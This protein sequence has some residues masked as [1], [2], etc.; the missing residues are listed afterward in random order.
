MT[1]SHLEQF[2]EDLHQDVLVRAGSTDSASRQED[3]FT[4]EVLGL[5]SDHNEAD[6]A[7]LCTYEIRGTRGAPA[8]KVSAWAL[9]GDGATL[10]LFV[11][12]YFGT[13][14]VEQVTKPDARKQFEML[15]SFL[16]RA[17]EGGHAR[18][19]E[20]SDAFEVSR[21]IFDSRVALATVRLFILTD[22]SSASTSPASLS[23]I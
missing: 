5:L 12:R 17:L 11:T 21:R 6:G 2:A 23:A 3:A 8:A 9:S 4:E 18:M 1:P 16:V 22:E 20:S 7:E 13:G 10:D 14:K 15:E 19:D